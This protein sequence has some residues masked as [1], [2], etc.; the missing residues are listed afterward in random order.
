MI[1]RRFK[2]PVRDSQAAEETLSGLL[3]MA[4]EIARC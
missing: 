2:A 4:C 1:L 3:S